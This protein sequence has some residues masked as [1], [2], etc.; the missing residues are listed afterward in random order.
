[1]CPKTPHCG[2]ISLGAERIS[3]NLLVLENLVQEREE[4]DSA[5]LPGKNS[6]SGI[7]YCF[8][9]LC[10]RPD[11]LEIWPLSEVSSFCMDLA[12]HDLSKVGQALR[13]GIQ[14]EKAAVGRGIGMTGTDKRP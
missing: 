9:R 2:D 10:K 8:G 4:D 14:Q 1:M 6:P 11:L 12:K 3:S 7:S 13:F 5:A